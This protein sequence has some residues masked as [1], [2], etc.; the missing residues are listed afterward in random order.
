MQSSSTGVSSCNLWDENFEGMYGIYAAT[1]V[2]NAEF[3]QLAQQLESKHLTTFTALC[4]LEIYRHNSC[5]QQ[6]RYHNTIRNI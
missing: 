1:Y 5:M 6:Y 3:S 2:Q 4:C